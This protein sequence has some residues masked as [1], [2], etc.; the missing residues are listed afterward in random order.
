MPAHCPRSPPAGCPDADLYQL[1]AWCT[2]LG[3][4]TGHLF[5]AKGNEPRA[6]HTVRNAGIRIVQQ[7]LDLDQPP[8]PLLADVTSIAADIALT[9]AV[10][11]VELRSMPSFRGDTALTHAAPNP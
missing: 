11:T 8:E 10:L 5:Y 3:L 1:L 6:E 7:A 9:A 4:D 2:T